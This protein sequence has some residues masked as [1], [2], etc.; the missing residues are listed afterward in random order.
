MKHILIIGGVIVIGGITFAISQ[1]ENKT[2]VENTATTTPVVETVELYPEE[3]LKDAQEAQNRVL[4]RFD[5]EQDK[6]RI[7]EEKSAKMA[8]YDALMLDLD[9]QIEGIDEKLSF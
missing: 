6:L 5:L 2:I 8:E 7:E 9:S 3:V 1:F 4:R